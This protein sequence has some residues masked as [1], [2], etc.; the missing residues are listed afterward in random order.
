MGSA[1]KVQALCPGFTYSEFHD[2]AQVDRKKR[3]P[4]SLWL[5]AEFVVDESLKGLRRGKLF[6]TPDWRYKA[7]AAAVTKLPV[8]ARLAVERRR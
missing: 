4:G 7:I 8:W 5:D 2:V 3:A 1:V 6:V